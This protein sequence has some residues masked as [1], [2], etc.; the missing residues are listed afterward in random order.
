[1]NIEIKDFCFEGR[2]IEV[3]LNIPNPS[4]EVIVQ[5][6]EKYKTAIIT[7]GFIETFGSTDWRII[8]INGHQKYTGTPYDFPYKDKPLCS[9]EEE[10]KKVFSENVAAFVDTFLT[11][12]FEKTE[13]NILRLNKDDVPV[14]RDCYWDVGD[15]REEWATTAFSTNANLT[16]KFFMKEEVLS[17]L[18]HNNEHL[19]VEPVIPKVVSPISGVLPKPANIYTMSELE[20]YCTVPVFNVINLIAGKTK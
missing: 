11:T 14:V 9:S 3:T 7:F 6:D 17:Y 15:Y 5:G 13:F 19:Y 16:K 20:E 1:M 12:A 8:D 18:E 2:R 4:N 10:V